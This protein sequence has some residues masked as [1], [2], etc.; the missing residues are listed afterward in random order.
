MTAP[1]PTVL[2]VDDDPEI[3]QVVMDV[4]RRAG[5]RVLE[6]ADGPAAIAAAVA[7]EPDL[8]FLD[9]AMPGMDGPQV[10]QELRRRFAECDLPV[11]ALSSGSEPEDRARALEAGCNLYLTKPCAPARIRQ[12]VKDMLRM[13]PARPDLGS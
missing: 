4:L 9:M 12:V 10:A 13:R 8:V 6:A 2:V 7:V 5:C 3:R 11:I 1:D